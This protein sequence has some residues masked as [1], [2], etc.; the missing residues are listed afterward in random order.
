MKQHIWEKAQSLKSAMVTYR[1]R[2]HQI[3]EMSYQEHK[4]G[5]YI[6]E[7]LHTLN[8]ETQ[9]GLVETG[10]VG[11][12]YEPKHHKTIAIQAGMDG[13]PIDE[14]TDLPFSSAHEGLSHAC[15]HDGNMAMVLGAAAILSHF[16]RHLNCNVKFIFQPGSEDPPAGAQQMIAEGVMEDVD[17]IL[18]T[19]LDMNLDAGKISIRTGAIMAAADQFKITILGTGG[20]GASP[21][22][23]I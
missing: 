10:L 19:H 2:L 3:P 11:T 20:H 17:T 5:R 6:N 9:T 12:L 22:E 15:G 21:H 13:V 8:V 4:T 7:V 23:G 14:Q 16:R 1:Q 18:T